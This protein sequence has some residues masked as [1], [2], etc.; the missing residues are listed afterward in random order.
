M[1]THAEQVT[2]LRGATYSVLVLGAGVEVSVATGRRCVLRC[3][4]RR[5]KSNNNAR[6]KKAQR[7]G[8]MAAMAEFRDAIQVS[9][10]TGQGPL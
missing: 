5:C 2:D 1:L 8:A 7:A 9:R 3:H 4:D 10:T 6:A